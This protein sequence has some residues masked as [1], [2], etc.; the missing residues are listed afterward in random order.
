LL[1]IPEE[2]VGPDGIASVPAGETF[3]H[4]IMSHLITLP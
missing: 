4:A 1:E 2:F 3:D